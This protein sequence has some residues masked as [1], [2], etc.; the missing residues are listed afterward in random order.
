M[1]KMNKRLRGVRAWAWQCPDGSLCR[2][3]EP[4]REALIIVGVPS[5]YTKAVPICMLKVT[6]Y[7][8]LLARIKEAEKR[9][10]K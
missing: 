6:D 4:S 2:W 1:P 7:R 10:D 3:S 9:H 8:R 5:T